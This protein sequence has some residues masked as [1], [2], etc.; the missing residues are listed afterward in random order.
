[1]SSIKNQHTCCRKK[2]LVGI[3]TKIKSA[4]HKPFGDLSRDRTSK[5]RK[6]LSQKSD[7]ASKHTA[8]GAFRSIQTLLM[9]ILPASDG[10]SIG[11]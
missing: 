4:A 6:S 2:A 11:S 9:M 8:A 3:Q 1:V 7:P 10:A 5:R